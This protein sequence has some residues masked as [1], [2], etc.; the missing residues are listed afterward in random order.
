MKFFE[1]QMIGER[2]E[3]AGDAA[4]RRAACRIGHALAPPLA[5]ERDD[6]ITRRSEGRDLRLP[7]V[8][9]AGVGMQKHDRHAGAAGVDEP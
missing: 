9:R 3:V 8:H 1:L 2:I 5:V 7:D 6:A 4:G